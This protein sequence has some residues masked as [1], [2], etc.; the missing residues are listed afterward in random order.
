MAPSRRQTS[1][2]RRAL[3]AIP[4]YVAPGDGITLID[5]VINFND[6]LVHLGG[7]GRL[8]DQSVRRREGEETQKSLTGGANG[9][10]IR[11]DVGCGTRDVGRTGYGSTAG[12]QGSVTLPFIEEEEKSLVLYNRA[13]DAPSILHVAQGCRLATA[14]SSAALALG[15]IVRCVGKIGVANPL[16][17]AV[18]IVRTA[19]QTKQNGRAAL[20]SKL[21]GRSFL[22]AEFL[23]RLRWDNRGRD[24]HD[25]RLV[26]GGISVIAIIVIEAIN[27]IVVRSGARTVDA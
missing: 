20:N 13:P 23:D 6:E 4:K 1:K 5:S 9:K 27:K 22:H 19:L 2:G 11:S 15:K 17:P 7:G 12:S 21:S 26:N 3:Q 16:C 18:K 14:R 8:S 10:A 25:T 24:A